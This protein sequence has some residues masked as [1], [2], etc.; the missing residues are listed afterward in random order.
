MFAKKGYSSTSIQE[1]VNECNISKGAFYLHFKSKEEL[2]LSIFQHNHDKIRSK[3]TEVEKLGLSPREKFK[4]Q[5]Y[6][7]LQEIAE[8]KDFIIM[9]F[10]E[11]ASARNDDIRQHM[12]ETQWE[13]KQWYEATLMEIYGEEA[14]P[15]LYD[16]SLLLDGIRTIFTKLIIIS[17]DSVEM[18]L[19]PSYILKRM[20]H[21]VAG[22]LQD[23]DPPLLNEKSLHSHFSNCKESKEEPLPHMV[24]QMRSILEGL[25][26]PTE[27]HDEYRSA[28]TYLEES[29]SKEKQDAYAI[30]GALANLKQVPELKAQC[31]AVSKAL[32]I[33]LV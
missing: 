8:H 33:K 18:R 27:L 28:L 9:H 23:N 26:M 30:Q 15:Y 25:N 32:K 24:R 10:R 3:I 14:A 19:L 16:L 12:K 5:I 17:S 4:E 31:Q 1:I 7:Q 6:V 13:M 21:L 11:Q 20:D 29:L 2:M 22:L